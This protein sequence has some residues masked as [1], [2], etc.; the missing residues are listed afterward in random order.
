MKAAV[1]IFFLIFVS[2]TSVSY[3]RPKPKRESIVVLSTKRGVFYFKVDK[4]L[5]GATI[6]VYNSSHDLTGKEFVY[7][8]KMVIDFFYMPAGSYLIKIKKDGII[9]EFQYLK[10]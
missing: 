5:L 8:R 1:K 2:T 7:D 10:E 3:A 9:Q 6:E 4:H